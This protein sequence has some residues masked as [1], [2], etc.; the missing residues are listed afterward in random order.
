MDKPLLY[1]VFC[2][3]GGAA[4]GYMDAGFRVVGVDILP[5][6]HYCGDG[7]IEADAIEFLAA[8]VRGDMPPADVLHASPPCQGYSIMRNLPWL[9]DREYPLLILPTMILLEQIGRPY[10]LENVMGAR[11]GAPGLRK[12]GLEAHGLQAG[13][14]CGGMFGRPFYRHRLF[15]TN[16][17]WLAPGHP[18][19][20]HV[21]R[22]SGSFGSRAR[23]IAWRVPEQ[24]GALRQPTVESGLPRIIGSLPEVQAN[25]AQRSGCGYGHAAGLALVRE[26]MEIDWP[27]TGKEVT[28][29]VPPC[30]TSWLGSCLLRWLQ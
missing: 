8:C 24:G 14:L 1:D 17:S 10:I 4:K 25:G 23:D 30:Y 20:E 6:P 11:H 21:I 19:H 13:W 16:W 5:Q 18:K 26:A 7:F 28:Q 22:P 27:S 12:R 2:G 15:A 3:A 9:R 29:M